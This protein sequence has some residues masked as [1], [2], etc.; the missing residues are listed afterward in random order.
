MKTACW[1]CGGHIAFD[2]V[3][4]GLEVTC[5]HCGL[6]VTLPGQPPQAALAPTVQNQA[7]S[8]HR[9]A[10]AAGFGGAIGCVFGLIFLVLVVIGLVVFILR[11]VQ[12]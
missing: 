12:P 1:S 11:S 3:I 4:A 7:P 8:K 9:S 2:P 6:K 5:P 10:I